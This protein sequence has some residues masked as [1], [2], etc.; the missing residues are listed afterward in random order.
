MKPPAV[1]ILAAGSS[2]RL[3]RSKQLLTY[4]G[5]TLLKR[6][7]LVALET[8][9]PTLVVLGANANA[10]QEEIN[11]LPLQITY[12]P[13]WSRGM[14]HSL[15]HG[16]RQILLQ[17]P[18]T[19]CILILVCDQPHLHAAHLLELK[20]KFHESGASIVASA[21]AD[22][23]GVPAIFGREW[24]DTILHLSDEQGARSIIAQHK[25]Q[26]ATV[27]FPLGAIDI[28]TPEDVTKFLTS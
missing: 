9:F 27:P 7:A 17:A 15:K 20:N 24:F 3:G 6:T 21:Y 26:V 4:Q 28:D 8:K 2:S 25:S 11:E 5:I 18:D 10:H 22:G 12:N 13:D 14:G 16:L 23:A 1:I 19:D